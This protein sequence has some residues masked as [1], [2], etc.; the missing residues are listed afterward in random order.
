M[1]TNRMMPANTGRMIGNTET[2][3]TAP[4]ASQAAVSTQGSNGFGRAALMEADAVARIDARHR[5]QR[6]DVTPE[7]EPLS[8]SL[9]TEEPG[10]DFSDNE[11]VTDELEPFD[12]TIESAIVEGDQ[13][14]VTI[15]AEPGETLVVSE[16]IGGDIV[17]EVED[18]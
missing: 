9:T 11:D 18:E 16:E 10:E 1:E 3:A 12:P 5:Q 15:T 2:R 13:D 8:P 17:V 14:E 6:E 7:L 4:A